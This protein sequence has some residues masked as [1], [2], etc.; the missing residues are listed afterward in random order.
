MEL[1]I[2]PRDGK[3]DN[4]EVVTRLHYHAK[5][6]IATEDLQ[7]FIVDKNWSLPTETLKILV[8][9]QDIATDL[10]INFNDKLGE[11]G[12]LIG[13]CGIEHSPPET[14]K[15][16]A[17]GSFCVTYLA[18]VS[19]GCL[20]TMKNDEMW[21]LVTL[22]DFNIMN[23]HGTKSSLKDVEVTGLLM[24]NASEGIVAPLN[25]IVEE[26]SPYKK[27]DRTTI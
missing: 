1:L 20:E 4:R 25:F 19:N 16:T 8:P 7:Y 26:G 5:V 6:L 2:N 14:L 3:I 11:M 24:K 10:V 12:K 17:T 22:S 27:I 21:K 18:T 9:F 13:V 15:L 23:N